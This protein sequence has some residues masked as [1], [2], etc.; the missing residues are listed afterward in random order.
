MG[1]SIM[2]R[3]VLIGI[4]LAISLSA[5]PV[6]AQAVSYTKGSTVTEKFQNSNYYETSITCDNKSKN[7]NKTVTEAG[8]GFGTRAYFANEVPF[9][10]VDKKIY[11][12]IKNS[13]FGSFNAAA[14]KA[15]SGK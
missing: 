11:V 9:E 8:G 1:I 15:C 7:N 10:V 5:T 3:I 6:L 12:M 2:R 13:R 14:Q 4:A